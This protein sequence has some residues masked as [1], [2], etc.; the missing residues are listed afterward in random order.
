[1]TQL[2][3]DLGEPRVT[4]IYPN[5]PLT[6]KVGRLVEIRGRIAFV[7]F[8]GIGIQMCYCTSLLKEG[9]VNDHIKALSIQEPW[10][11]LIFTGEKTIETRTWGTLHRGELLLVGS[12]KPKGRFSGRAA[13]IVDVVDC[14]LMTE[15]DEV[16]ACCEVYPG[17]YAWVLRNV[18]SVP[19]V[20]ISGNLRIYNV[21]R[22]Q[23]V[24]ESEFER[25]QLKLD[26]R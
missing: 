19:D 12:K 4:F 24:R 13:C 6:G 10:L 9:I 21:P 25:S 3:L 23:L 14:R 1:M 7:Y 17:A 16:G 2:Q 22:E 26:L 15:D 18:R 20:E 11:S 8:E 5:D